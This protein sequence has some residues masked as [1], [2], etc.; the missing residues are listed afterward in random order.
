M[1][2][3]LIDTR[4]WVLA[5]KSA[6]FSKDNPDY[7]LSIVADEVVDATLENETVL[8]SNQ[9]VAEIYHV[10]TSRGLNIPKD[11]VSTILNDL[12]RS[13]HV[14]YRELTKEVLRE[15]IRLS[16][17]SGIH[18]W[19][20][21]VLLPFK[22]EIEVVYTMDTHFKDKVFT[23]MTSLTGL[24]LQRGLRTGRRNTRFYQEQR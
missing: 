12:L 5:I 11:D 22:G 8:V 3:I 18:I 9:L 6:Y 19:D 2:R 4:I 20:F 24:Q 1:K 17:E 16:S 7:E 14:L 10:A 21:L 15:A 23:Q 13:N